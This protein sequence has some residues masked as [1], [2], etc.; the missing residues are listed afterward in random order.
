MLIKIRRFIVPPVFENDEDKT[1]VAAML[2]T[3]LWSQLG[4]LVAINILFG[5]VGLFS[6]Q[7]PQNLAISFV[8]IVMFA[9]MLILVQKGF[10]RGISYL[11]AFSI[12]GIIIYSIA[13]STTVSATTLSGLLIP[14]MMAGLFTGARGTMVVTAVNLLALSSLGYFYKQGWVALPPLA[15]TD[16]VSFGAISFTSALLLGLAS[17]SI[18]DSLTRARNDQK[19]L[20]A[21]A[22]TLEQR[23]ADRTKEMAT[24]AEISTVASTIL[25]TDKLL[26]DV[27]E[28]S[29]ERFGLYHAHIYLLNEAGDTLVLASGAGE[30][31]RQM[32]TEK[33]SIPLD[34][35]QSLVAR[36][37]RERKG[38]TVNDVTRTPDFLPNPLLPDT[39]SEL[40]VPMIVGEKVIGVFDVQ[41]QVI[42]RFNDADIAVQ[43][44]LASQVASAVRNA[45]LYTEAQTRAE[46]EALIASIGQ[47]IQSATSVESVLQI[48][49]RELGRAVGSKQTRVILKDYSLAVSTEK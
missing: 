17:K 34:H 46:R 16:L 26:Q 18:Q 39:Y 31:G 40:A 13:T 2:N 29:K 35:E 8:A 25:E 4:V 41:S 11:L 42:G 32:V 9:G 21:L 43:T 22:Q 12:T 19:Q 48:T 3:I 45:S 15:A 47:R 30:V 10:V 37:A 23:V 20:A 24:V 49:A 36:A 7:A 44:T 38:V 14:V 28:L 33:L 1:R 27:V 5:V 6:K